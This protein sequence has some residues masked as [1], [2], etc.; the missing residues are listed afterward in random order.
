VGDT[1]YR[2]VRE[3]LADDNIISKQKPEERRRPCGSRTKASQAGRAARSK[4]T[5]CLAFAESRKV[6][7][8]TKHKQICF[9]H[10]ALN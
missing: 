3:H 5:I 10:Q 1:L 4:D 9:I 8:N 7:R 2:V 6:C